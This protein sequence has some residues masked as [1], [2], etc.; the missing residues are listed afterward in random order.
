[1]WWNYGESSMGEFE[2]T[3]HSQF[4]MPIELWNTVFIHH[5]NP[6]KTKDTWTFRY[7]NSSL[8]I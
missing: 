6:Q 7:F 4:I 5:I 8:E 1:M 2:D 3:L